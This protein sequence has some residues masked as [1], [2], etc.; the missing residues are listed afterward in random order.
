M[1]I[2][3]RTLIERSERKLQDALPPHG[4]A[5]AKDDDPAPAQSKQAEGNA[6]LL[7]LISLSV[8]Y[9]WQEADLNPEEGTRN[10]FSLFFKHVGELLDW[11]QPRLLWS[12]LAL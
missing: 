3:R 6:R 2:I 1:S 11:R 8:S 4:L 9:L 12:V 7:R 10:S 5:S